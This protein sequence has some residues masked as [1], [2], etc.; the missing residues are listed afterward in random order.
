MAGFER[1]LDELFDRAAP[2]SVLDVGCGEGVLVQRWAQRLR[3]T[4]ASSA[5][6]CEEESIQAGWASTRRRTS[7]TA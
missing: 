7:S 1:A 5:S 6:T 3:A 2:G 4:R